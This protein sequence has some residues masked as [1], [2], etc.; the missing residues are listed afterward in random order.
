MHA[1]RGVFD[2][3]TPELP[4][5]C[6]STLSNELVLVRHSVCRVTLY[7]VISPSLCM[8]SLCM[9]RHSS[10]T[11]TEQWKARARMFSLP[12]GVRL[13]SC[14]AS[15]FRPDTCPAHIPRRHLHGFSWHT[16]DRW[17]HAH[18]TSNQ[19]WRPSRQRLFF[20]TT[21]PSPCRA[22]ESCA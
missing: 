3:S 15:P 14:P 22:F 20:S 13:P 8:P 12:Q 18:A 16:R 5:A 6:L 7:A 4:D 9:P 11:W 21:D 2:A 17:P 1:A 19:V 10:A